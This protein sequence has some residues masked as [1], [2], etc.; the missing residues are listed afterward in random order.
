M[1][2]DHYGLRG[3]PLPDCRLLHCLRGKE[4][5]LQQRKPLRR[6]RVNNACSF[7]LFVC[8]VCVVCVCVWERMCTRVS[9]SVSSYSSHPSLHVA[10]LC[11]A[12]SGVFFCFPHPLLLYYEPQPQRQSLLLLRGKTK[13]QIFGLKYWR[14]LVPFIGITFEVS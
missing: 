5:K 13:G 10:L 6:R 1:F 12:L 2:W 3:S 7:A 11:S 4:E 8:V 9:N 14:G